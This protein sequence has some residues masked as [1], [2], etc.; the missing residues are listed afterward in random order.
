MKNLYPV[1]AVG[2]SPLTEAYN[3]VDAGVC[4]PVPASDPTVPA[5]FRR[6][7][8]RT[9]IVPPPVSPLAPG[10]NPSAAPP[11]WETPWNEGGNRYPQLS[12]ER[13]NRL[14]YLY[15][16]S[17]LYRGPVS[18]RVQR[19]LTCFPGQAF[20][21]LRLL[22]GPAPEL[23]SSSTGGVYCVSGRIP[24]LSVSDPL[25]RARWIGVFAFAHN[26]AAMDGPVSEGIPPVR[27]PVGNVPDA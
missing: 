14:G 11:P 23:D 7:L 24:A 25:H 10:S 26:I 13:M 12:P 5:G 17:A 16:T 18:G 3:A 19:R 4:T 6:T 9:L 27:L 8:N 1:R 22:T 2:P 20:Q 21:C 15:G